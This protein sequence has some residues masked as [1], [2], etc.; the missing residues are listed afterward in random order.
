MNEDLRLSNIVKVNVSY[1]DFCVEVLNCVHNQKVW[2]LYKAL[3]KNSGCIFPFR[4]VCW[5]CDRPRVIRLENEQRIHAEGE[6]A[7]E[8]ADGSRVYAHHGVRLPAAYGQ[9]HPEQWRAEWLLSEENAELR[10]VLIQGIGYDRI[11]QE[12]KATSLDTW[13]EYE[14]LRINANL[15]WERMHLLK[16]TCPSTGYIH[17]I[18]VPPN[19]RSARDAIKW[20][21]WDIDPDEFSV[22]S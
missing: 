22:Q 20:V 7:I 16:M 15:D 1:I 21:N 12:L 4:N 5:V 3:A 2:E 18:R 6:P 10:R 14:L 13:Q 8:F 17:A 9:V 19:I 11:C